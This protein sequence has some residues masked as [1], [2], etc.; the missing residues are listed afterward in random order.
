VL[1]VG[2]QFALETAMSQTVGTVSNIA[3]MAVAAI[4][5]LVAVLL[6]RRR[7]RAIRTNANPADR[8]GTLLAVL[9]IGLLA[10]AFVKRATSEDN[11]PVPAG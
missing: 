11:C 4:L 9:S 2:D 8:V 7:T 5:L 3:F 10:W 1:S 6:Y